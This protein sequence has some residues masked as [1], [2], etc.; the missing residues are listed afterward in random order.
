MTA[1]RN[2]LRVQALLTSQS[3]SYAPATVQGHRVVLLRGDSFIGVA[4]AVRGTEYVVLLLPGVTLVREHAADTGVGEA[5]FCAAQVH[6]T[7]M[8]LNVNVEW[9]EV[10]ATPQQWRDGFADD[11]EAERQSEV[12]REKLEFLGV[13][14]ALSHLP[15]RV[16]RRYVQKT[17]PSRLFQEVWLGASQVTFEIMA[18]VDKPGEPALRSLE[19]LAEQAEVFVDRE[20]IGSWP[21]LQPQ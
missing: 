6:R 10:S 12:F 21:S 7:P 5:L 8:V 2:T 14:A 18:S 9:R 20:I 19:Q 17:T 13:P 11:M 4:A 3:L 1:T 16:A 15:D